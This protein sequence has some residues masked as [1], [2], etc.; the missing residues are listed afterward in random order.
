M[1]T[2]PITHSGVDAVELR[3]RMLL[4]EFPGMPS[5]VIMERAGCTRGKTVF[6]DRV[7]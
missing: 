3:T 6:C 2:E 4:A 7:R 1:T 5:T